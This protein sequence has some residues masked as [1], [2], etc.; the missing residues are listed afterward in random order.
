MT[1]RETGR[2]QGNMVSLL[3]DSISVSTESGPHAVAVGSVDSVWIYRGTAAPIL[4]LIA[5]LPCALYG[6][7]V[8]AFLGSDPDGQPSSAKAVLYPI[9]G[10]LAGG[11][12]CG[13]VGA[14]I[15]SLIERWRLEFARPSP[16][17]T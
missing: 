2:L 11:A 4:G 16:S 7:A 15:G 3:G 1:N 14:G 5:A 13:T 12:L 8:G 10:I 17:A 9:I 6:G